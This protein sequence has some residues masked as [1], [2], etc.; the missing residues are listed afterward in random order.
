MPTPQ[1]ITN[2]DDEVLQLQSMY[3]D[4]TP[5]YL[6][7]SEIYNT[8]LLSLPYTSIVGIAA[9]PERLE[10]V[11]DQRV[12]KPKKSNK[13]STKSRKHSDGSNSQVHQ[14]P[15]SMY[16]DTRCIRRK[17]RAAGHD[18]LSRLSAL[19][20]ELCHRAL[21]DDR[22]AILTSTE[23]DDSSGHATLL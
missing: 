4:I 9:V 3:Y 14:L 15:P 16:T 2:N 1:R 23:P 7:S 18:P 20:D 11:R 6:Q 17:K 19:R 8:P 5:L 13:G 22:A 21:S 12:H 10:I